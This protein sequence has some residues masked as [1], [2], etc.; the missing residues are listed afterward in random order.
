M[1]T[2]PAGWLRTAD[3][4]HAPQWQVELLP[5]GGDP[6]PGVVTSGRLLRN[7]GTYPKQRLTFTIPSD[8]IPGLLPS[9]LLPYGTQV[10]ASY[11]VGPR[12]P[13]VVMAWLHVVRSKIDRPAGMW[14]VEAV[15]G[16]GL[17]AEDKIHPRRPAT[18][19][20]TIGA[21]VTALIRRTFPAAVVTVTGS[22]ASATIPADWKPDPDPWRCIEQLTDLAGATVDCDP[23]APETFRVRPVPEIGV[24]VDRVAVKVNMTGYSV[25]HERTWNA[26]AVIYR[27]PANRDIVT[28]TGLWVD[29]RAGSPI[30]PGTLGHHVTLVVDQAQGTPT[31]AQADAAAMAK[32]L[33]EAG[34][35]RLVAADCV[36]RPWLEPGDTVA[37]DFAGGPTGE[38]HLLTAI[39]IPLD[40]TPVELST[41]NSLYLLPTPNQEA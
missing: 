16:S 37:L 9:H 29:D 27:D 10:R 8:G 1:I 14:T 24:P 26:V 20:G 34:R 19:T 11:R 28:R 39:A 17:I 40:H 5:K 25:G 2:V 23:Q 31:Q 6:I 21:A 15:D 35:T 38:P 33:R 7:S 12:E 18:L 36:P 32:G 30:A 22:A 3:N 13:W 41:R 4:T